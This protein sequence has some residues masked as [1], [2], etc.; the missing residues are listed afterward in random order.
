MWPNGIRCAV[1]ITFDLDAETAWQ[2]DPRLVNNPG[3]QS[4]GRYGPKVGVP[5]ILDLL[6]R[7]AIESTFFIPGKIA[8]DYP[9]TI[10]AIIDAGHEIANHSYSHTPLYNL[11]LEE[12]E[13]ELIRTKVILEGFGV[14][15]VGFRSP[16]EVSENTL[17]LLEKHKYLYS[18]NLMDDIRPYRH[19][20][21]ELIE[22]PL[23][24]ITEDWAH[25][26]YGQGLF[27]K[28]IATNTEVREIWSDEFEGIFEF[29]G[30]FNLVLHPQVIGR[31][32]RIKMLDEFISFIKAHD[33]VWIGTCLEIAEHVA[34]VVP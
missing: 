18:S 14:R 30:L 21:A 15:I 20:D 9:H 7:Q 33:G 23:Q 27:I 26:A 25:F 22:L 6:K 31:P 24:W 8:E 4:Q 10:K 19:S 32:S 2:E 13:E 16:W 29:S 1:C 12:E 17:F 34:R 11:S 5:I 28:K 3:V